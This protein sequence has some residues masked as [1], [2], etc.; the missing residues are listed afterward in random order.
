LSD[1]DKT[2]SESEEEND[3]GSLDEDEALE[4]SIIKKFMNS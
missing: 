2:V 1:G 3:A 4:R